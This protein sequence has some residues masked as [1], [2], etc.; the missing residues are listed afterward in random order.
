MASNADLEALYRFLSN[1]RVDAAAIVEPHIEATTARSTGRTIAIVHDSTDFAFSGVSGETLGFIPRTSQRGFMGHF[2]L[3]VGDQGDALGVLGFETLFFEERIRGVVRKNRSAATKRY[4]Q[5]VDKASL[6]WDRMVEQ[7]RA[8]VP[9]TTTAIHVMDCEADNYR[10]F[11][12]M[13]GAGDRFV[14]RARHDRR[15]ARSGPDGEWATVGGVAEAATFRCQREVP[16][17]KRRRDPALNATY[18]ARGART[19]VLQISA[20]RAVVKT[21]GRAAHAHE[22]RSLDLNLVRVHELETPSGCESVDWILLTTE[23]VDTQQQAEAVVD[24]YRRRWVIEE[25]FRAL[26][27][28]CGYERR[29]LESRDALL[30]TLSLLVPI[31]WQLLAVRDAARAAPKSPARR[32]LR[33]AQLVVLRALTKG[34]LS[35]SPTIEEALLAIAAQGGHLKRNGRPGWQT[36]GKGLEKLWWAELGYL[37]AREE[38]QG[39]DQ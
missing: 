11:A 12:M 39:S 27:T 36:L 33:E 14:I 21:P 1:D 20:S 13:V 23:A 34:R 7:T 10:L 35:R 24:W 15:P 17:S 38:L 26:K 22:P 28:G 29:Q 8:L 30:R 3:A 2:A 6:R 4:R 25:Y 37:A 19:A 18:K 9:S 31:A 32:M 16:L 5:K